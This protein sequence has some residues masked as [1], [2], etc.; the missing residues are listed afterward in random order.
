MREQG[1]A[2]VEAGDVPA[3]PETRSSQGPDWLRRLETRFEAILRQGGGTEG[4]S[5]L[6]SF[7][8]DTLVVHSVDELS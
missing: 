8:F 1:R 5:R 6:L 2:R 4:H 3:W 7:P